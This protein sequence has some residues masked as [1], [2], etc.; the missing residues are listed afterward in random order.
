ML[1]IFYLFSIF[2]VGLT[3]LGDKDTAVGNFEKIN[4]DILGLARLMLLLMLILIVEFGGKLIRKELL[5]PKVYPA[6]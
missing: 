3:E 6:F 5:E 4:K 2:K 1:H